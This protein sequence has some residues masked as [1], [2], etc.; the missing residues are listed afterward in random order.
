MWV[1]QRLILTCSSSFFPCLIF[2]TG[3]FSQCWIHCSGRLG[4]QDLVL[5]FWVRHLWHL[6]FMWVLV[7]QTWVCML[8]SKHP[9]KVSPSQPLQIFKPLQGSK[10]YLFSMHR[11]ASHLNVCIFLHFIMFKIFLSSYVLLQIYEVTFLSY[12]I[13]SLWGIGICLH[14]PYPVSDSRREHISIHSINGIKWM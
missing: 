1:G 12:I 13:I 2:E 7:I 5:M 3:S 11:L 9:L 8:H 14:N 6:A 4:D 10:F